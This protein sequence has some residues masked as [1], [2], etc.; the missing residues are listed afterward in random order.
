MQF[1]VFLPLQAPSRFRP[2]ALPSTFLKI[3]QLFFKKGLTN[4]TEFDIIYESR[5]DAGMA[6]SVEHV[7]GNDEVI[8]SILITSSKNLPK[9]GRFF[10]LSKLSKQ[11]FFGRN[12]TP[13]FS[14]TSYIM[15]GILGGGT[16]MPAGAIVNPQRS[17]YITYL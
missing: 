16:K 5:G 12:N 9:F 11:L 6:Q 7:I 3:F 8:S 17:N 1:L 2:K 13:I 15:W 10:A 14:K 4:P